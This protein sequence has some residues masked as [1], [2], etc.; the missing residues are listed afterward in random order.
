M[1]LP[2]I[3]FN[4]STGS[5]TAASGAG[6]STALSGSQARTPTSG[7]TRLGLF[8]ATDLSGVLVDGSAVVYCAQ[9]S[10]RKFS[11]VTAVKNTQQVTTGNTTAAS[12]VV[13][14]IGSTS[15]MAA[16]DL[17]T[18]TNAGGPGVVHYSYILTVDSATQITLVTAAV[19]ASTGATITC[20]RQMTCSDTWL[21]A[22]NTAWAIGGKRKDFETTNAHSKQLF[23]DAVAG[24][25]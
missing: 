23:V 24:W 5:N 1:A 7:G 14:G 3:I 13:T 9:A 2:T 20:P 12:A 6:P 17:V 21:V 18:I 22:T 15:G 16:G 8:D 10:A 19:S 11:K 25:T 4:N